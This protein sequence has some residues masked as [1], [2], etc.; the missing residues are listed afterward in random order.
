MLGTLVAQAARLDVVGVQRPG[1]VQEV[2]QHGDARAHAH[3]RA[4][5]L[6]RGGAQHDLR[7]QA[8]ARPDRAQHA[9]DAVG[10]QHDLLVLRRTAPAKARL[11]RPADGWRPARRGWASWSASPPPAPAG[12]PAALVTMIARSTSP[13]TSRCSRNCGV[14][15]TTATLHRGMRALEARQQLRQ[16]VAGHQAGDADGE[17]AGQLL[18]PAAVRC[19]R[20]RPPRRSP[21]ARWPGSGSR[22]AS[23]SCRAACARTAACPAWP[24]APGCSWSAPTGRC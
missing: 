14:S 23:A 13:L 11:R 21:C 7:L 9:L 17:L 10:L 22:P 15:S 24:P 4:H 1:P 19:R 16:V 2:G 3:Q 18:L 12:R 20:P 6:Q 5:R 8:V